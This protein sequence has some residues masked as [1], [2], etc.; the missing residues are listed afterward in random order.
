MLHRALRVSAIALSFYLIVSCVSLT[1]SNSRVWIDKFS[2][3]SLQPI[4]NQLK[5]QSSMQKLKITSVKGKHE[6]ILQTEI[7]SEQINMVGFSSSGLVLFQLHWRVAANVEVDTKIN[8]DGVDAAVLLAYYQ[9]SNW[10]LEMVA[11]GL[12]GMHANI[13]PSNSAERQFFRQQEL[14]FSLKRAADVT[15]LEHFRDNYRIEIETLQSSTLLR[16]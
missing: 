10:P 11:S 6:L 13:S 4:P 14:V 8:I 12:T 7:R 2:S 1:E 9:L 3:Y 5:N 16:N 15:V